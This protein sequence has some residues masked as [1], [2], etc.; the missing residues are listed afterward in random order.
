[1]SLI[2]AP[3]TVTRLKTLDAGELRTVELTLPHS[4]RVDGK[5]HPI[6]DGMRPGAAF[7]AEPFGQ[8]TQKWHKRLYTR[9]NCSIRE[10]A[11]LETIINDTHDNS[12]TSWWWQTDGVKEG[13]TIG[14]RV[15]IGQKSDCLTI[16]EH[17]IVDESK[18][19]TLEPDSCWSTQKFV[20]VAFATG[21]TPFLAHI[22]YMA[23]FEF[24]RAFHRFD[25]GAHYVLI[26]SVR[27]PRQLMCHDELLELEN[28]FPDN[29]RYHPVLTREWPDDWPYTRKRIIKVDE[30]ARRVDLSSLLNI[31][32]DL[33][34]RHV[35]VCG[36]KA[37]TG[38]LMR[39][40]EDHHISPQSIKAEVW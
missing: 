18:S 36:G 27:N 14:V 5:T 30:E 7:L 2:L 26:V 28:R 12:D 16:H 6:R 10:Q 11:T 31:V 19:L 4:F 15:D 34:D 23:L 22:R 37:A 13:D 9:S 3:A 8:R 17:K 39:G 21:I 32:P 40:L 35:R 25:Q 24:G 33:G 20:G 29:F 1:M 38:Q